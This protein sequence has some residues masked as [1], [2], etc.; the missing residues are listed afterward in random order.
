MDWSPTPR[1]STAMR[2]EQNLALVGAVVSGAVIASA[3]LLLT[4]SRVNP[5]AGA[6]LRAGLTDIVTPIWSVVRAPFDG[7]GR[8]S[9]NAGDYFGAVS[10]NRQLAADLARARLELQRAAA[11]RQALQ[12]LR[13]LM[14]VRDPAVA[15]VAAARIVS[16]TNGAA[17]RTAVIAAGSADGVAAGMP[18]RTALGLI[19][20]TMETG[21]HSARILLLTDPS[22]RIPVTI[23]RTGQ[24][25]LATGTNAALIELRDRGG[26]DVPLMA[27]DAVV[28]SGDGGIYA[29]GVPV[30]T[31]VDARSEPP[32]VRPAASPAGAGYVTVETAYLPLPAAAPIAGSAAQIPIEARKR[33]VK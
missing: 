17:V 8:A 26:N 33:G 24:S 23:V 1:R 13:A 3:L 20:R 29:P 4:L 25:A 12:Q 18:V 19:G 32:R 11:D 10:R 15:P 22:S 5:A 6:R 16:A 31:I 21:S 9:D 28:T 7:I 2:R 27:G 30:G 14:K